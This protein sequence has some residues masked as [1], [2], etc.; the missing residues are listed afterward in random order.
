LV[1]LLGLRVETPPHSPPSLLLPSLSSLPSPQV[2]SLL[3]VIWFIGLYFFVFSYWLGIPG[4]VG[5]IVMFALILVVFVLPLPV[6]Y[7]RSR[8][9]LGKH[10]VRGI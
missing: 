5:P 8:I 1:R 10:L 2:S 9:W 4:W 7:F 3:G 6:F